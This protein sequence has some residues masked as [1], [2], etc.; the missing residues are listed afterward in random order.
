MKVDGGLAA[1]FLLAT[2]SVA[3]PGE[4]LYQKAILQ[5]ACRF[6]VESTWAGLQFLCTFPITS[7]RTSRWHTR[8]EISRR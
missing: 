1:R 5:T 3:S 8:H 4:A 2:A 6:A 7:L